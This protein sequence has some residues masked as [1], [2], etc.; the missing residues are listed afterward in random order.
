M[1][2]LT[3][4]LEVIPIANAMVCKPALPNGASEIMREARLD[5]LH[6]AFER[7]LARRE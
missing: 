4:P 2:I 6:A 3:M 7:A 1:D 5:H